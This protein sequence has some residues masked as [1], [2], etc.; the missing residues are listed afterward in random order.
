MAFIL[1]SHA[2]P[3]GYIRGRGFRFCER[4]PGSIV[5]HQ[6]L[7]PIFAARNLPLL[8]PNDAADEVFRPIHDVPR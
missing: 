4:L 7:L 8:S 5:R 3:T 2:M 6:L 1:W